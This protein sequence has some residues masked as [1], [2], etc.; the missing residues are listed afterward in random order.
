MNKAMNV[1]PK[2][3]QIDTGVE[4][5]KAVADGLVDAL[6]DTYHLLYKTHAYHWNVEGP[7]F[8]AIHNLT[9]AQYGDLFAATDEIAERARALGRLAPMKLAEILEKSDVKDA[10]AKVGA[11]DMVEDLASDH[12][13]VAKR[14]HG[15]IKTAEDENDPVTAD[16]ITARSAFHEKAAW[17]LRA[18]AK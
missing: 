18:I 10:A 14:M 11:V 4:G 8:Y 12:E 5:A 2:V 1:T 9:E 16:L 6:A 13:A 15:L 17:M 3:E 7:L